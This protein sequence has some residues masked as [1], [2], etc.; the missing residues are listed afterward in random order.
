MKI[1]PFSVITIIVISILV[2]PVITACDDNDQ[3]LF[4]RDQMTEEHKL[5]ENMNIIVDDND[6]VPV[7]VLHYDYLNN[8]YVSLR[9][10]ASAL[11]GTEKCFN[12]VTD[13]NEIKIITN[14]EY[15]PVGDEGKPFEDPYISPYD[16]VVYKTY[17][18]D[19][20]PLSI[21]G[22]KLHYRIFPAG[23]PAKKGDCYMSL[24]DL[25]MQLDIRTEMTDRD[26]IVNTKEV[27][28]ADPGSLMREEF[29]YETHSA[30]LGD[31]S[32][33]EVYLSY[34]PDTAVAIASTSKLMTYL[35][36]MDKV[37]EGVISADDTITITE[38]S[39]RLSRTGDGEVILDEGMKVTFMDLV[40][41][42]LVP[43]SDECSLALAIHA[44]G[45]EGAFVRW[46]N[47]KA[48]EL[49]LSKEAE[50]FNC[51]G[52]PIYTND[53]PASKVQNRMSA[54]DMFILVRHILEKYPQVLE[55]T[56]LQS[57]WLESLNTTV[58]NTNPLLY[59]VP[60][61]VGLKTGTTNMAGD[62]VIGVMPVKDREGRSHYVTVIQFGAEDETIR[63]TLSEELIRYGKQKIE[64][65]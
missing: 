18:M 45:S 53:I 17:P 44:A 52:L 57:V 25:V 49:N 16:D 7:K 14:E 33:G 29:Y 30:L 40:T 20:Y 15:I 35:V 51:H 38:E 21:D 5:L 10:F 13:K 19:L 6:P 4:N 50:F 24:T 60:G 42:M 9:D 28:A 34:D 46:M 62:C 32:T 3:V 27:Y 55:I 1:R 23:S 26:I 11:S 12:V 58:E 2:I 59:N 39:A 36:L 65:Q 56:S 47:M 61:V 8:R 54:N 48:K 22:R 64:Q 63:A 41:A 37:S 31:A 43:S